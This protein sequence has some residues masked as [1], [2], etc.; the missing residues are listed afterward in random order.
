MRLYEVGK[1][2]S[3]TI[4]FFGLKQPRP[5]TSDKTRMIAGLRLSEQQ[6]GLYLEDHYGPA[7]LVKGNKVVIFFATRDPDHEIEG[8]THVLRQNTK[9]KCAI[10]D[11]DAK[12]TIYSTKRTIAWEGVAGKNSIRRGVHPQTKEVE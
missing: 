8:A 6:G 3:V 9:G 2:G 7:H 4:F 1:I 5:L 11:V 12:Y 10:L